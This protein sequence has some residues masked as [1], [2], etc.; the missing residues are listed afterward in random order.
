MFTGIIEE[1][2]IVTAVESGTDAVR[3][4]IRG[5]LAVE[6][7]RRGDSIAVSGV[8]L[9][10]VEHTDEGFTA[11]VMAQTL[12]M[13]TLDGV[14]VGDPVNLERAALVGD[15]LGGHIVQGHIDGT[16]TLLRITPGEAWRVLRFSLPAGLAALVVDKGSIAVDGVS[17]TVS[18]ISPA[19]QKEQWFEVS[20]IPETLAVTTLGVRAIG[21]QVNIETDI[22]ARHV[23]RMLALREVAEARS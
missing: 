11:D 14:S 21:E 7:V 20:L 4:S 23:E 19:A 2:G 13:S 3:L 12:R 1:R 6:G 8:C 15:R 9:T 5:P 18:A 16:A 22:L 10:V 17:L